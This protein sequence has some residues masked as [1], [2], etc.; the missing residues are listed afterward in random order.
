MGGIYR[1]NQTKFPKAEKLQEAEL[2]AWNYIFQT[3]SNLE[4][5]IKTLE[6]KISAIILE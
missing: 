1:L 6:V 5:R 3:L 4:Q 2:D